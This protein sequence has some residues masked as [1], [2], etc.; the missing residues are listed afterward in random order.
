M[1]LNDPPNRPRL[2]TTIRDV[3]RAFREAHDGTGMRVVE[4]TI[5]LPPV[6]SYRWDID[7]GLAIVGH[8][9]YSLRPAT[10]DEI[11]EFERCLACGWVQIQQSDRMTGKRVVLH[12]ATGAALRE[13]SNPPADTNQAS[14]DSEAHR[15]HSPRG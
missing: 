10:D 15:A 13:G 7:G 8:E 2:G 3:L 11:A 4:A 12:Q 6:R 14:D 9:G 1:S 5:V